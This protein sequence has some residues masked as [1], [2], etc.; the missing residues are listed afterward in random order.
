MKDDVS[1]EEEEDFIE[2]IVS[3]IESDDETFK[4]EARAFFKSIQRFILSKIE[5]NTG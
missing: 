5:C 4:I 1:S 2:L 3:K